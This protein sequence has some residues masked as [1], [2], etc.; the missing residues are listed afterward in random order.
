[1]SLAIS[2]PPARQSKKSKSAPSPKLLAG[3]NSSEQQQRKGK[4]EH[5]RVFSV[6]P[7][8]IEP[9]S[10]LQLFTPNSRTDVYQRVL[11]TRGSLAAVASGASGKTGFEI[12]VVSTTDFAVKRRITTEAEVGD[13]DLA[14]D[15]SL[16]YCTDKEIFTASTT[17]SSGSHPA[18]TKLNFQPSSPIPGKLRSLR[19]FTPKHERLVAVINAPQRTGATV[20]LLDAITGSIITQKKLHR[21]IGAVTSL[22]VINLTDNGGAVAVAGADASIELLVV[23]GAKIRRVQLF[24]DVHPFQITKVSFSPPPPP[25]PPSSASGV[26]EDENPHVVR[27]AT[28][29][30][31]N[32]IVVYTFPLVTTKRG[33]GLLCASRA[34]MSVILSLIAVVVFAALLQV[35][36]V[37]RGG[38][39]VNEFLP[40]LH[41]ETPVGTESVEADVDALVAGLKAGAATDPFGEDVVDGEELGEELME[42]LLKAA[43]EKATEKKDEL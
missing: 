26:E 7:S 17:T 1:M 6:S 33:Y 19:Y 29:S 32:T 24:R 9:K 40:G 8:T 3:I 31:G 18:P 37:T 13:L 27:L 41:K 38:L 28:T 12:V 30:I 39:M 5:F 20:L 16:V 23:D 25:P 42:E 35:V 2:H 10:K 36:F 43:A 14:E 34:A 11:R 21:G 4:N 22:D 15:G